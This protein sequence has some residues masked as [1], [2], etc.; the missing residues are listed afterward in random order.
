MET[1]MQEESLFTKKNP[2]DCSKRFHCSYACFCYL[3]LLS[4]SALS[5][6][7]TLDIDM[8]KAANIGLS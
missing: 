4:L 6:T 1:G 8:A 3:N 7:H 2:L 5:T